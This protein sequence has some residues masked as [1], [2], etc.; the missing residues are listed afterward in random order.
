M[1]AHTVTVSFDDEKVSMT[2]IIAALNDAGY[3][4]K[5]QSK[6]E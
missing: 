3:V 6:I 2:A 5:G 4:V 1:N